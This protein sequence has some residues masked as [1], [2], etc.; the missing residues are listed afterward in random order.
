MKVWVASYEYPYGIDLLAFE[1]VDGAELWRQQIAEEWF[2][3]EL[4][5][6]DKPTDPVD[7]ADTYFG[8]VYGEYFSFSECEVEP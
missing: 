6:L 5:D 8:N 4:P 7:L 2:D 3:Q 1:T